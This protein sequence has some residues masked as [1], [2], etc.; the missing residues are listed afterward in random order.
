VIVST[1]GD[2]NLELGIPTYTVNLPDNLCVS[3]RKSE[4]INPDGTVGLVADVAV[5]S[6]KS[7]SAMV[8]AMEVARGTL[9]QLLI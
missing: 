2:A 5:I 9:L 4:R 8:T 6:D 3:I 1:D 7:D